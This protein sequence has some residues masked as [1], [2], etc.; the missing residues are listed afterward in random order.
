M[1][2]RKVDTSEFLYDIIGINNIPAG[3]IE[4]V[5]TYQVPDDELVIVKSGDVI[6]F[7]WS[8][9]VP[10]HVDYGNEDDDDVETLTFS[11]RSP[12]VHKVNDRIDAS[13]TISGQTQTRAYSIKAIVSGISSMIHNFDKEYL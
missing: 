12:D 13:A 1:V 8:A 11:T 9:P 6:G 7:A 4:Q 3:D 5:V 10:K 2:L